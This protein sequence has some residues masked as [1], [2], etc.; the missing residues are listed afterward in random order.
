MFSRGGEEAKPGEEE[1]IDID[2]NDPAVE[3]AA[4]KIQAQFKG[5]KARKEIQ[6]KRVSSF[7]PPSL[8]L[9]LLFFFFGGGGGGGEEG[10]EGSLDMLCV[11]FVCSLPRGVGSGG[12]GG[13]CRLQLCEVWRRVV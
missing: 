8:F 5:F 4:I 1:E 13:E 10:E 6:T 3:D 11:Q 9:L 12:G 7:F 2:L